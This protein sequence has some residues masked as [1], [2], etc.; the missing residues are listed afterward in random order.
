MVVAI[1]RAPTG[2]PYCFTLSI[3]FLRWTA[4][5]VETRGLKNA[6]L[7]PWSN[8]YREEESDK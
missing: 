6:P 7:F 8:M 4:R 3:V 1:A 5:H 2:F